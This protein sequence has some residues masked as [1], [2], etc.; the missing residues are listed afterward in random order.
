M[1]KN[2]LNNLKL[3]N[4]FLKENRSHLLS[5]V[6]TMNQKMIEYKKQI[7]NEEL[8]FENICKNGKL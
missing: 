2:D 1:K 7:D 8:Y 6:E 5:E 4:C 3:E